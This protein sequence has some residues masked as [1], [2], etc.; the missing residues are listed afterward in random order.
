M[1][2]C[3]LPAISKQL[4]APNQGRIRVLIRV[5]DLNRRFRSVFFHLMFNLRG[6]SHFIRARNAILQ[7]SESRLH[8]RHHLVKVLRSQP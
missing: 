7:V 2:D 1:I 5:N 8:R 4:L 6:R 3:Q